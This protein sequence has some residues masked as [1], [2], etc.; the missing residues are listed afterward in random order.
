M[1][2][3]SVMLHKL[4]SGMMIAEDI[5]AASQLLI[6]KDTVVTPEIIALLNNHSIIAVTIYNPKAESSSAAKPVSEDIPISHSER[7]R[8]SETF[9]KFEQDFQKTTEDFSFQLNDIATQTGDVDVD[10]LFASANELISETTN[11]YQLMDILSNIR[12]FDDSTYAHSLNVA[13]LAN[14]FGRW[15]HFD[16]DDLKLL[17]VAGMLHDIGKILIPPEIIKKPGKLTDEEFE[18]IKTHPARGYKLLTQKN[19]DIRISQAALMHHEKYDG[20]GYPLGVKGDKISDL[21]KIITIVDVYEA[22][23]ANR[24]Y[25]EGLCPFEVIKMY[26]DEGYQKYDVKFLIPFLRGISDT[27]LHNTVLLSDGRKG[28]V[29]MTNQM[30]PSKPGVMIDNE[31]I[32]LTKTPNLKIES[33]L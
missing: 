29:I 6:Q 14:I 25:R 22:L 3:I 32:D 28:E 10:G 19:V 21:A 27:Y 26:E 8:N 11:T 17:T 23:T 24:C 20:S 5:Y 2:T 4:N 16:D 30:V 31:Y 13:M 1:E 12:Y 15:M 18:I 33:I 9:K 7:L